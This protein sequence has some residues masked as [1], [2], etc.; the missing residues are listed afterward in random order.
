MTGDEYMQLLQQR[1]DEWLAANSTAAIRPKYPPLLTWFIRDGDEELVDP[2]ILAA[3]EPQPKPVRQPRYY[4]PASHWRDRIAALEAQMAPLT[5]PLINDRAAAGGV[6]LGRKRTAKIQA[7]ED[8]RLARYV[9]L[10]KQLE[11]A[12]SMLRAAE[13]REATTQGDAA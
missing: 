13:K 4:R 5:E 6:A 11:H 7:R 8:S 1:A 12:Q 9:E 2:A 10:R 3:P